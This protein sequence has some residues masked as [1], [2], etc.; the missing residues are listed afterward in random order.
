MP[1]KLAAKKYIR[2]SKR[3]YQHNLNVKK[4]LKDTIKKLEEAFKKGEKE[5]KIKPLLKEALKSLDRA[6]Q[7]KTIKK[8]A[9]ARKK[10][11]LTKR[12]NVIQKGGK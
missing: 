9:A 7:K 6:A 12:L 2:A 1:N 5:D 11:R 3:R 8:N 4:G 10:S